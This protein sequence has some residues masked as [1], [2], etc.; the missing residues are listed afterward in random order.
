MLNRDR[1]ANVHNGGYSPEC[2]IDWSRSFSLFSRFAIIAAV[3]EMID[4]TLACAWVST[5]EQFYAAAVLRDSEH[6]GELHVGPSGR[7][8]RARMAIGPAQ[9]KRFL[10]EESLMC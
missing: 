3:E 2:V 9:W 10:G 6:N 1:R 8:D 7:R 4:C 5:N